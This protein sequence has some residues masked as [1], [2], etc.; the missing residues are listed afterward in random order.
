MPFRAVIDG[1]DTI[2]LRLPR[3]AW[4]ELGVRVKRGESVIEMACCHS[5]GI[6]KMSPLGRQFFAHK[7]QPNTCGWQP[8]SLEH[9]ELKAAIF[10]AI[11]GVEG[12]QAEIE[13]AGP[14]WRAD[15]MAT[16]GKVKVAFEVQLSPQSGATTAFREER[17]RAA[18]V[19]PWW[20]VKAGRNSGEAF[21][22]DLRTIIGQE[23]T[24][25]ES[26]QRAVRRVL[27]L[28]ESQVDIAKALVGY[29][30]SRHRAC[31]VW[32]NYGLPAVIEVTADDFNTISK[33]QVIVIGELGG[34]AVP[35]LEM[36]RQRSPDYTLGTA[37]QFVRHAGAQI[38]G[39]GSPA[40]FLRNS[41]EVEVPLILDRIEHGCLVWRGA[42]LCTTT[43][44]RPRWSGIA[45]PARIAARPM[46]DP[47]SSSQGISATMRTARLTLA[48]GMPYRKAS[49]RNSRSGRGCACRC[50]K[51]H[52]EESVATP[53]TAH[54]VMASS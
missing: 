17:Y 20:I 42:L 21:G 22:S 16:R 27:R 46:H 18:E 5:P 3:D 54:T 19:L 44:S 29:M 15:V 47:P 37:V 36:V 13:A 4:R 7:S 1:G 45:R 38:Q 24:A 28:V 50:Q 14:D 33:P 30:R 26:A 25:T 6:M 9:V 39:F 34:G 35:D 12:W 8:E 48:Y 11:N 2:S 51:P 41:P 40:F 32:R 43:W 31:R 23:L 49:K 52:P 53:T 10:D